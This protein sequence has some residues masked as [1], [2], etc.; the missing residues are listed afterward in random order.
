MTAGYCISDGS[1]NSGLWFA[2]QHQLTSHQSSLNKDD[3]GRHQAAG[4]HEG[5]QISRKSTYKSSL[6]KVCMLRHVMVCLSAR[7]KSEFAVKTWRNHSWLCNV[8]HQNNTAVD[9]RNFNSDYRKRKK[10]RSRWDSPA[11]ER[12]VSA[13]LATV[14]MTSYVFPF[15]NL[16]CLIIIE[17]N[18]KIIF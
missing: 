16:Y 7:R 6:D 11:G 9:W 5:N 2:V 3:S 4:C 8:T 18:C 1:L 13:M 14:N 12:T 15:T 10:Y 17:F